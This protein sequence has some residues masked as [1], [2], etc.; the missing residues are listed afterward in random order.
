MCCQ[1]FYA[2]FSNR[3]PRSGAATQ[4]K[5]RGHNKPR[6]WL[7][8]AGSPWGLRS[9]GS[10]SNGPVNHIRWLSV[11]C[12]VFSQRPKAA[13]A[14]LPFAASRQALL[15]RRQLAPAAR[16][17]TQGDGEALR[18]PALVSDATSIQ[19]RYSAGGKGLCWSSSNHKNLP[20]LDNVMEF[21][22]PVEWNI[23]QVGQTDGSKQRRKK[24]QRILS[25][26]Q[27]DGWGQPA[28]L[29]ERKLQL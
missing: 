15:I 10:G 29:E 21:G 18:G 9:R 25:V 5:A 12:C 26:K 1:S 23:W 2:Q 24:G 3:R 16:E 11:T 7:L 22:S 17:R 13:V 8:P 4:G 28:K 20:Q 14:A 6:I 27:V 19:G